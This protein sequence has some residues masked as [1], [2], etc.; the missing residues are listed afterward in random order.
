MVKIHIMVLNIKYCLILLSS[1]LLFRCR[2][3][4]DISTILTKEDTTYW[5]YYRYTDISKEKWIQSLSFSK[6][7]E[8]KVY[9]IT[10]DGK[11]LNYKLTDYSKLIG[12]CNKWELINDSVINIRCQWDYKYKVINDSTISL[13]NTQT[14]EKK[15]LHKSSKNKIVL[16]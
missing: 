14:K 2:A 16:R 11:R 4:N 10:I 1:I 15:I 9:A 8:C 12:K 6:N 3:K 5:D 7:G 13:V